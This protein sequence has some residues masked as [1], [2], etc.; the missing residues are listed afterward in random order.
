V[1]PGVSNMFNEFFINVGKKLSRNFS[2][3]VKNNLI[4]INNTVYFD[5]LFSKKIEKRK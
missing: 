3:V 4:N 2:K 1:D 5:S